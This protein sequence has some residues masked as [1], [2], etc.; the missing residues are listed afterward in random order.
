M[1]RINSQR[2]AIRRH[3]PPRV[4]GVEMEPY[5]DE[6]KTLRRIRA[7]YAKLGKVNA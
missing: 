4:A 7:H 6:V 5:V 3:E 1:P 2:A